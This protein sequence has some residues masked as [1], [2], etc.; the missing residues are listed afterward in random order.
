MTRAAILDNKNAG[1][2]ALTGGMLS[3]SRFPRVQELGQRQAKHPQ[4]ADAEQAAS[5]QAVLG[6]IHEMPHG[7]FPHRQDAPRTAHTSKW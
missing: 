1:Y 5:R 7:L 3:D 4:T 2:V 6:D